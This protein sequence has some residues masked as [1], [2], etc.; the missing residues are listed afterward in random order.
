MRVFITGAS[1][2]IGEHLAYV[3]ARRGSHLGLA[4]RRKDQLNRVADTCKKF[5]ATVDVEIYPMDVQKT[6]ACKEAAEAFLQVTGGI[7]IV[8]ANAGIGG[9]DH[10]STGD[11]SHI[12]QMLITNILGVTNTVI[13]FI[14][15]MTTQKSGKI[16][17]ISSVAGFRGLG[18]RGG[19]SASKAAVRI[20]AD[21][22]RH[23]LTHYGIQVSTVCPGFI[24]TP[25]VGKN[26][27]PMPFLMD[28]TVAAEKI[29]AAIERGKKTYIFPWQWRFIV[30]I[31]RILP[32][33]LIRLATYSRRTNE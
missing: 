3:Y 18:G 11:A 23:T 19:Y 10:L 33:V 22:W 2:G 14:P 13:P 26:R 8:I 1:S 17:I 31:L 20:M 12:N 6:K 30:P 7:D 21:S 4:A 24:E 27:F 28:V 16:V 32:D 9:P 25:M 29:V 5:R 15:T